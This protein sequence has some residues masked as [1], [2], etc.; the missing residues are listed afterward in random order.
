M[1]RPR[2]EGVRLDAAAARLH[3][4]RYPR[5]FDLRFVL[6]VDLRSR[7]QPLS[8][9]ES[10]NRTGEEP[11]MWNP[12]VRR[13]PVHRV[14]LAFVRPCGYGRRP[15]CDRSRPRPGRYATIRENGGIRSDPTVNNRTASACGGLESDVRQRLPRDE[16]GGS[17]LR[18]AR[19]ANER[20]RDAVRRR[21]HVPPRSPP[22]RIPRR[23]RRR[24][25]EPWR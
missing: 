5:R 2:C 1:K 19:R 23:W 6:D 25:Q 8:V 21:R 16:E 18:T 22:A 17:E 9:C 7:G 3:G 20:T 12:S 24:F 14:P 11:V 15:P 10:W 13:A 4:P